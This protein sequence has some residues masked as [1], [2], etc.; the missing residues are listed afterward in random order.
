[1]VVRAEDERVVPIPHE[2]I[3]RRLRQMF[4]GVEGS[5]AEDPIAGRRAEAAHDTADW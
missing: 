4:A 2:S 3:R 1:M 5:M